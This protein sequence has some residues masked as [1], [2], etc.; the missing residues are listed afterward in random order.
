MSTSAAADTY[1]DFAVDPLIGKI[2]TN[3]QRWEDYYKYVIHLYPAKDVSLEQNLTVVLHVPFD[4][5][6]RPEVIVVFILDC[7]ERC[8]AAVE[9][10]GAEISPDDDGMMRVTIPWLSN[11]KYPLG[12]WFHTVRNLFR[13][14][15][16]PKWATPLALESSLGVDYSKNFQPLSTRVNLVAGVGKNKG[17][18]PY[19]EDV[20]FQFDFIQT[21]GDKGVAVYG[22]LDGHG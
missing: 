22:V 18:R 2:H 10:N 17:R 14:E 5:H 21:K 1:Y 13:N 3:K 15:S 12:V 8:T 16:L 20:S 19:M 4:S 7:D 6:V 9:R 11:T